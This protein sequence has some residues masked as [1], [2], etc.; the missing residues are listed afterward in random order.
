M[1]MSKDKNKEQ[2]RFRI[3]PTARGHAVFE[4]EIGLIWR[5]LPTRREA[6]AWV[7]EAVKPHKGPGGNR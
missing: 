7:A 1:V 5:T 4:P 3:Y 6:E 2:E